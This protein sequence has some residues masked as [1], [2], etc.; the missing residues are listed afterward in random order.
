M[1]RYIAGGF[2]GETHRPQDVHFRP[3]CNVAKRE[4]SYLVVVDVEEKEEVVVL[5]GRMG[6]WILRSRRRHFGVEKE[7]MVVYFED[8][9]LNLCDAKAT[10]FSMNLYDEDLAKNLF[11]YNSDQWRASS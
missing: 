9:H 2:S 4:H 1:T 5:K 7:M 10:A 11:N 3:G 8:L 6:W